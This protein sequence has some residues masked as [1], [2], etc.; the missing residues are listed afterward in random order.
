MGLDLHFPRFLADKYIV[1]KNL[2]ILMLC[3]SKSKQCKVTEH[4]TCGWRHGVKIW[5]CDLWCR[6]ICWMGDNGNSLEDNPC[7]SFV[8]VKPVLWEI[9]KVGAEQQGMRK[10]LTYFRHTEIK[11]KLCTENRCRIDCWA[12]TPAWSTL[13]CFFHIKINYI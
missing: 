1:R 3:T 6:V 5:F 8:R 4:F 7:I 13:L 11:I 12:W 9:I 10:G 2:Y